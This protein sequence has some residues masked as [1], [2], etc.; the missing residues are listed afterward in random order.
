MCMYNVCVCTIIGNDVIHN[1]QII[2]YIIS[3]FT[4]NYY[5]LSCLSSHLFLI[6]DTNAPAYM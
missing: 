3:I 6:S 5:L 1:A 4:C 2:V